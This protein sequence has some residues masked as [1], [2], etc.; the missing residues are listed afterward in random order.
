MSS[1]LKA[2]VGEKEAAAIR[3]RLSAWAKSRNPTCADCTR[4][5]PTWAS[6]N[7]GVL[8]CLECAGRHRSLGT[9]ISKMRSITL[10]TVLPEEAFFLVNMSNAL[11]NKYW[12][13]T[14]SEGDRPR[15][16]QGSHFISQ[17]Y[18]DRRWA[19]TDNSVLVPSKECVPH[20]HP[21]WRDGQAGAAPTAS[22]AEAAP[23]PQQKPKILLPKQAVAPKAPEPPAAPPAAPVADLIDFGDFES[24]PEPAAT[25]QNATNDLFGSM[26]ASYAPASV[27]PFATAPAP[28]N[29][30]APVSSTPAAPAAQPIQDPFASMAALAAPLSATPSL[31]H[32]PQVRSQLQVMLF[33]IRHITELLWCS[34]ARLLPHCTVAN[35]LI[36]VNAGWRQLARVISFNGTFS[37]TLS[38]SCKDAMYIVVQAA[39]HSSAPGQVGQTGEPIGAPGMA[40]P[41]MSAPAAQP[42]F[43]QPLPAV[44]GAPMPVQQPIAAPVGM[45]TAPVGTLLIAVPE[46]LFFSV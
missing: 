46:L 34:R 9:H 32:P 36:S 1:N 18:G 11:A 13:A 41:S 45:P 31:Q 27:D 24:A 39:R 3:K 8:V 6:V 7:L 20:S 28:G 17:K 5:N 23:A 4:T 26:G 10:D 22:P 15:A 30:A 2:A 42:G 37:S 19:L 35:A 29:T 14:L 40:V 21:W 16:I 43:V 25:S 33:S 12:E 38:S 44:A